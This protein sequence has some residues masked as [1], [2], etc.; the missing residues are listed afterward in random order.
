MPRDT[1]DI[2]IK[3]FEDGLKRRPQNL[4]PKMLCSPSTDRDAY[5][6]GYDLGLKIKR[7]RS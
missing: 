6:K 7:H 5:I 3:G 1:S 2:F 4:P